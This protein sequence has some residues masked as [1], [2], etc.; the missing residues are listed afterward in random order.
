MSGDNYIRLVIQQL[1]TSSDLGSI[2]DYF[3]KI[4]LPDAP[5]TILFN[6]HI[7]TN[8]IFYDNGT[9]YILI[10]EFW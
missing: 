6:T 9:L 4:S 8:K 7:S 3:A 5:G 2:K 10:N 1:S